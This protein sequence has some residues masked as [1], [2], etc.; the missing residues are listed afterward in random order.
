MV[1]ELFH[2]SRLEGGGD[3]GVHGAHVPAFV[4]GHAGARRQQGRTREA[5]IGALRALADGA[6]QE[7]ACHGFSLRRWAT[8]PLQAAPGV[9]TAPAASTRLACPAYPTSSAGRRPGD[10]ASTQGQAPSRRAWACA[11]A[12]R[13][14][15]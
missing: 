15:D 10:G 11:G 2:N 7:V 12:C 6:E 14:G 9:S 13:A 1:A 4:A 5:V 3:G 8:S